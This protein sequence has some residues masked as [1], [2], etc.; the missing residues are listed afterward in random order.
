MIHVNCSRKTW[1]TRRWPLFS[2]SNHQGDK[3]RKSRPGSGERA[4]KKIPPKVMTWRS[5]LWRERLTI[6]AKSTNYGLCM[7]QVNATWWKKK[8]HQRKARRKAKGTKYEGLSSSLP[9][10]QRLKKMLKTR[11]LNRRSSVTLT[12]EWILGR[13]FHQLCRPLFLLLNQILY[14]C[15]ITAG[16]AS[17]VTILGE[18][19]YYSGRFWLSE[20]LLYHVTEYKPYKLKAR[21]ERK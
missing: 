14:N 2:Q 13:S 4:S 18:L 5:R 9:Q 12:S 11:I 6:G 3:H 1:T 10:I 19:M 7:D 20:Y 16:T 17:T 15:C 8:I 21:G